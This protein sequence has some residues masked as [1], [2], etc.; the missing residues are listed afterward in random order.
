[1]NDTEP[2]STFREWRA[3][4]GQPSALGIMIGVAAILT[5]IAPFDMRGVMGPVQGFVYWA[6]VVATTYSIGFITNGVLRT[7]VPTARPKLARI[8]ISGFVTGIGVVVCVGIINWIALSFVPRGTDLAMFLA[9]TFAIAFIVAFIFNALMDRDDALRPPSLLDRIPLDKRAPLVALSVQD[10][11][12]R[13]RTLKG[14]EVILM[15]LSDAMR[16]VGDTAG[17]QVHRSH[18][19]ATAQVASAVR[20]GDGAVLTM[21]TGDIIPVSR[22]NIA[23]IREAG[24]LPRT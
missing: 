7:R 24:L 6:V 15:R 9:N 22:T 12:V 14:E 23:A 16:E 10:H 18:W 1:M 13:I 20:K 3:H 11:Y 4:L 17:V 21:A 19:I 5:L 2:Q 8:A